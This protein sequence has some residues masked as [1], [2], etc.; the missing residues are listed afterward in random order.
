MKRTKRTCLTRIL[1][2]VLV[3]AMLTPTTLAAGS[4]FG[5]SS[6]FQGVWDRFVGWFQPVQPEVPEEPE[7]PAA[8][9]TVVES[10]D[11]V[12]NGD[13]LRAST[14]AL[15]DTAAPL[16]DGT[17]KYFP[18]TMFDYS[19][20][21]IN[22]VTYALEENNDERQWTGLY[23]NDGNPSATAYY[24]GTISNRAK[25]VRQSDDGYGTYLDGSYYYKINGRNY[26]VLDI[27]CTTSGGGWWTSY[28]W[29]IT[30]W[31]P[32]TKAEATATSTNSAINLYR[33]TETVSSRSFADYNFWTGKLSGSNINNGAEGDRIYSGLVNSTLTASGDI[34]FNIPEPGVF[35]TA[36]VEGKTVYT[37]V[38]LPFEYNTDTQYYVFDSDDFG[39]Y[40]SADE[41]NR[42]VGGVQSNSNM[43]YSTTPQQGPVASVGGS[44][45][46]PFN[47]SQ[48]VE[49]S[50]ANYH[51]GM[52]AVIDFTMTE[53]GCLLNSDGTPI[54]FEF[55]GDDDV[56]VFIDGV[57]VL[58]IG[59]IHNRLGGKLDFAA[60]TATVYREATDWQGDTITYEINDARTNAKAVSNQ[61]FNE[62]GVRGLLNQNIESFAAQ[63]NHQLTIFYLERG[64]GSSNCRISFNLPVKDS[65]SVTKNVSA[66]DNENAAIDADTLQSLRNRQ[67]TFTLYKN[68]DPVRNATYSIMVNGQYQGTSSTNSE[69][70]FSLRHGETARF[71]TEFA[72][73][74]EYYVVEDQLSSEYWTAPTF[75]ATVTGAAYDNYTIGD[76][77]SG[78]YTSGTVSMGTTSDE[79]REAISFTCTNTY[80]HQDMNTLDLANETIVMDYGLPVKVNVLA[81]DSA[82]YGQMTVI[83]VSGA[84]YGEASIDAETNEIIYTLNQDL[85][86]IEQ[87][88]YTVRSEP[89][90]EG[91]Q[92][93]EKTATLT[94]IP[95]TVMYYEENFEGLVTY[96]RG[97]WTPE[98]DDTS[99]QYQET[100]F[101][102]STVDSPYGSD[103]AYRNDTGD[104][105]G[106][107]MYVN[108][109]ESGAVFAYTFTGTGTSFFARTDQNSAYL[110]VMIFKGEIDQDELAAITYNDPRLVHLEYVDTRFINSGAHKDSELFNIPVFSWKVDDWDRPYGEYTV[111]VS[112]AS[113]PLLDYGTELYLDGIRVYNPL[114]PDDLPAEAESAYIYDGEANMTV[115]TLREKIISDTETDEDG[116]WVVTDGTFVVFTDSNGAIVSASEYQSNG[117][118]QEVYLNTD[119]SVTFSLQNF[120]PN[121]ITVWLGMKAPMGTGS[122]TVNGNS[123]AV[124]N[125]TDCFYDISNYV[126]TV[127]DVGTFTIT[128]TGDTVISL[129]DIKVAGDA[130]FTIINQ[131]DESSNP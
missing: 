70:K 37:N 71:T 31:N 67:Y 27:R 54:T 91:D 53:D 64:K 122:V 69:G 61:L 12:D 82:P 109:A 113:L 104:S 114:N 105:N 26:L 83:N 101:V 116:N 74:D 25:T 20:Q 94:I 86:D 7:V 99:D 130:E 77:V 49:D 38:G 32:D 78:S 62:N 52:K 117:P 51:F 120:D 30:Y 108:T 72:D 131:S 57:L 56:W 119:Q 1:V 17:R 48:N 81:N 44:G 35:T 46:F 4:G 87:L 33:A 47:Q 124:N 39:A 79:A 36:A 45:W 23:F 10:P 110:Q 129:T 59:G 90:R 73:Y 85:H 63:D 66:L 34:R 102:S 43:Y 121:E 89:T 84:K 50:E 112:V 19:T 128:C 15:G 11:T 118:K 103:V 95:A 115:A 40:G 6:W 68:D 75:S 22:N 8:E 93:V 65:V 111:R 76:Q 92:P 24:G 28:N 41:N 3:V 96:L 14:Y 42:L 106:T 125:S 88:T 58:D 80:K 21:V 98:N 100:G 123:I 55:S 60:N 18:V 29:T 97:G 2:L 5:L 16:A 127:N 126:N 9:L 107:S 13:A